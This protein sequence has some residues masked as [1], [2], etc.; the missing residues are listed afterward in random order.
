M[1]LYAMRELQR[2]GIRVPDDVSV[3]GFDDLLAAGGNVPGLCTVRQPMEEM[4]AAA[5]HV[6]VDAIRDVKGPARRLSFPT[7]IVPR[8]SCGCL[9]PISIEA[10]SQRLR[11]PF[12]DQKD[13]EAL[14]HQ[15]PIGPAGRDRGAESF[16]LP[17]DVH[18]L[19]EGDR[20]IAWARENL[21]ARNA[22]SGKAKEAERSERAVAN[23]DREGHEREAD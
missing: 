10:G 22:G 16:P 6:I 1:A 12:I 7:H 20:I 23:G 5:L 9:S 4:G 8:R 18:G 14:D 21:E 2:R 11:D 3:A 17:F 19:K 15:I 13:Y